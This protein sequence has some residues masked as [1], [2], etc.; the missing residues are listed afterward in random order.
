MTHP[1]LD[2]APE[3]ADALAHGRAVV[4][5]ESTIIAHGMP[6]PGNVVTARALEH[7][8]HVVLDAYLR[9]TERAMVLDSSGHYERASVTGEPFN[10]Q[11]FLLQHYWE[12]TE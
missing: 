11:Q 5:L 7:V 9:D 2:I 1:D 8:R 3:I 6:Y 12:R 10:A 4:A